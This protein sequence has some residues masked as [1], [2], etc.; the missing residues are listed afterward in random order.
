MEPVFNIIL[1][2]IIKRNRTT[3]PMVVLNGTR[4][5]EYSKYYIYNIGRTMLEKD[6][7][8]F[9]INGTIT[10]DDY[11][12]EGFIFNN[13]SGTINFG[14]YKQE[15][16]IFNNR[17]GTINFDDYKQEKFIFNFNDYKKELLYLKLFTK[18]TEKTIYTESKHLI[19]STAIIKIND[20][21]DKVFYMYIKL[22]IKEYCKCCGVNNDCKYRIIYSSSFDD[23]V[24]FIYK[25][26]QIPDF[27]NSEAFIS[28]DDKTIEQYTIIKNYNEEFS[29]KRWLISHRTK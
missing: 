14:D 19:K 21:T 6:K 12:Q 16:F 27:L 15:K 18:K 8:K 24:T 13:R 11:K 23:L 22:S 3:I 17:S 1:K 26:K 7:F 10:F 25:K 28:K 20:I 5:G 4:F 29:S 9:K 2:E